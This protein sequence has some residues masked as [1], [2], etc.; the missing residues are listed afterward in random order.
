[1][2]LQIFDLLLSIGLTLRLTRVITQDDIGL[3][4]V[5]GPVA[6]WAMRHEPL[7]PPNITPDGFLGEREY[8]PGWRGRLSLGLSCP[9][10]IGF[11]VGVLVLL[12]LWLCGGPGHAWDPWRWVAGAF[13]LNWVAAHVGARAGD[14]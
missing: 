11:W 14:S 10:C 5:R 6:M 2:L 3:W 12:S 1:M 8:V 13:A 4:Y 9:F 7:S